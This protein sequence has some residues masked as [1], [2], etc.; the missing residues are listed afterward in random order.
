ML[1]ETRPRRARFG[2]LLLG[3]AEEGD[4]LD[5]KIVFE[6][7]DGGSVTKTWS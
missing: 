6:I 5:A 2:A 7:K 4:D 3:H 1:F